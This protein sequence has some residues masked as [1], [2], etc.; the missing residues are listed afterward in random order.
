[1]NKLFKVVLLLLSAIL[2][3]D[4]QAAPQEDGEFWWLK[5][6]SETEADPK[7]EGTASVEPSEEAPSVEVKNKQEGK[8]YIY[9]FNFKLI[10]INLN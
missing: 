10:L 1:M 3:K 4:C 5:K 2:L 8:I 6:P 9:K 7:A